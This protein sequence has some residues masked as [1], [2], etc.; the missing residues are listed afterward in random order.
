MLARRPLALLIA[1]TWLVAACGSDAEPGAAV[2]EGDPFCERALE[3]QRFEP[4]IGQVAGDA[5]Q[6]EAFVAAWLDRLVVLAER[7]PD[8]LVD[9][10]ATIRSSVEA[11]DA[12]LAAVDYEL[13]ELSFEQLDLLNDDPESD[14]AL[15]DQRFRAY[16]DQ[17]CSGPAP[18]PLDSD[19]LDELLG[20]T[21][22][23]ASEDVDAVVTAVLAEELEQLLGITPEA[24]QCVAE[25]IDPDTLDDVVSGVLTEA[26]TDGL[27]AV[28]DVCGI[29]TEDLLG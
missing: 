22:E 23:P 14:A 16:V 25:N 1:I 13:L 3:Y 26:T 21:G 20:D 15:A 18:A 17:A 4:T 10:L 24:S 27:L 9:D 2:A 8:E 6:T 12:E 29:S 28:L 19:E 7:S 11:L 5:T